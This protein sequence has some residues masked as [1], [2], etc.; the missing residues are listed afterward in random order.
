MV[1]LS[2]MRSFSAYLFINPNGFAPGGVGGLSA[3]IHLAA[4]D[5][6][7]ATVRMLSNSLFDPGIFTIIM[8]IPLI[9]AAFCVL[10][11]KFA[12]CTTVCVLL[13]S[14]MM[15]LLSAV[16][17]PQFIANGDYGLMLIAAIAGGACA[18]VSM[19]F[20]LRQDLSIGGTDII[21]KSSTLTIRQLT[22]NGGSLHAIAALR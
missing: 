20:M 18:G 5:S 14:G 4:V 6:P 21:G 11:K 12:A 10:D 7:N 8:N 19:G 3:L 15:Y 1:I 13:F 22:L 17:C 16:G 9:I 2:F